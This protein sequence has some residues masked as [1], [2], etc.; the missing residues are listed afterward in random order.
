MRTRIKRAP[1]HEITAHV[2]QMYRAEV[3]KRRNSVRLEYV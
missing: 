2:Y 1:E 3:Y